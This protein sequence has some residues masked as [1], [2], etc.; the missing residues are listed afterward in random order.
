METGHVDVFYVP[1]S[2]GKS[3]NW[4]RRSVLR[5][6]FGW[7][8]WKLVTYRCSTCPIWLEKVETGHVQVFYVPDLV[9]KSG[10]WSRKGVLRARFVGKREQ[11]VT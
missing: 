6:R 7:K 4:S 9:G 5:A 1:Y 3:G 8:K 2:A 10:N 11:P